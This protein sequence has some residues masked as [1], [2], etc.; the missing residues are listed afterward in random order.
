MNTQMQIS[1]RLF[2]AAVTEGAAPRRTPVRPDKP[3]VVDVERG[4]PKPAWVNGRPVP[5]HPAL[6]SSHWLASDAKPKPSV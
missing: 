2:A 4:A 1:H 6:A 3:V 5:T